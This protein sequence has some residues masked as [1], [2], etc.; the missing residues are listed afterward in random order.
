LIVVLRY[1]LG[2]ALIAAA[3]ASY[4]AGALPPACAAAIA[5]QMP[6]WAPI[7]PPRDAAEWAR[8]RGVNAA[9]AS[10]D[11][12]GNGLKDWAALGTASGKPN[13]SVCMNVTGKLKLV[14]IEE[15]Y[16]NDIVSK[17]PAGSRHYNLETK[18]FERIKNDGISVECFEQAG[19]TYVHH[20]SGFRRIVD[21]D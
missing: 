16:C 12:D 7:E 2:I 3:Q 8:A 17:S 14:V 5:R 9:V 4:A 20:R 18:R 11:F 13:L 15:P 6:D 21:S 10:G 1:L 19:A